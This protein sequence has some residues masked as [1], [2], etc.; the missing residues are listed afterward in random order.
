MASTDQ[1]QTRY[2]NLIVFKI[3]RA[4]LIISIAWNRFFDVKLICRD[5][6]FG[7]YIIITHRLN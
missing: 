2:P 4:I 1:G 6:S 5:L 3:D 7:F